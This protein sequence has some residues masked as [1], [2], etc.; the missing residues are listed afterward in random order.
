[1]QC[2]SQ[3]AQATRHWELAIGNW[4]WEFKRGALL[5]DLE[6]PRIDQRSFPHDRQT[7]SMS[8]IMKKKTVVLPALLVGCD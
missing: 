8:H 7:K 4:H 1:M 3:A 6:V 5:C 2:S